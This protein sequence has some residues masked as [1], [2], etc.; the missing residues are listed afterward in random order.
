[1]GAGTI[2]LLAA[3]VLRLEGLDVTVFGQKL[4]PYRNSDLL[5][6]LGA[7]KVFFESREAFANVNTR[8]DLAALAAIR[9]RA[10]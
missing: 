9:S 3:L 6:Q 1:M 7:Q 10:R 2:G 4:A 5:E 8:D